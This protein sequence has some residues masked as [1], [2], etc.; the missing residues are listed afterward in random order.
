VEGW[1][2]QYMLCLALGSLLLSVCVVATG[3]AITHSFQ[4]G[5]TAGSYALGLAT[6]TPAILTFLSAVL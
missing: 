4:D 2:V 3:T 1:R 6:V 5:L